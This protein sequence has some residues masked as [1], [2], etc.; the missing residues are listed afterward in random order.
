MTSRNCP[1]SEYTPNFASVSGIVTSQ[2][3][4]FLEFHLAGRK[5]VDAGKTADHEDDEDCEFD[6]SEELR[7]LLPA[8]PEVERGSGR[9]ENR[10]QEQI[11]CAACDHHKDGVERRDARDDEVARTILRT[12]VIGFAATREHKSK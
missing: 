12:D 10:R 6:G 4:Y 1:T 11:S 2:S 3:A 5:R 7:S 8:R 9:V